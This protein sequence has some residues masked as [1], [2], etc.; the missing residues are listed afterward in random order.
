MRDYIIYATLSTLKL[1]AKCP[2]PER[3]YAKCC[4]AVCRNEAQYVE[5]HY[6]ECRYDECG[7]AECRN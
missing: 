3:Y 2:Y 5:N 6:A 4:Y 7:Y 1:N